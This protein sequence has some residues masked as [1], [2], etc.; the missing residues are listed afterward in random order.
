MWPR[1]VLRTRAWLGLLGTAALTASLPR[2]GTSGVTVG[3]R[4]RPHRHDK[5]VLERDKRLS[6]WRHLQRSIRVRLQGGHEHEV[7]M[8]LR[9][10]KPQGDV[11]I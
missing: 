3:A 2:R 6:E 8:A 11:F 1:S 4:D 7:F 5:P 10:F 9:G